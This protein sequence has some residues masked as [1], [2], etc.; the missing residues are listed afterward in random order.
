MDDYNLKIETSV[1]EAS[2]DEEGWC[3]HAKCRALSKTLSCNYGHVQAAQTQA[4]SPHN[5]TVGV[6]FRELDHPARCKGKGTGGLGPGSASGPATAP[7]QATAGMW[8]EN[9]TEFSQL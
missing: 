8:E 2:A 6:V 7:R 9:L 3:T 4:R 5:R 1:D